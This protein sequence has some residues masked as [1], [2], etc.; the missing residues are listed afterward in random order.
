MPLPPEEAFAFI[1]RAGGLPPEYESEWDGISPFVVASVLWSLYSFLRTPADYWETIC[2]AIA[3]GGDTDTTAAMAGAISGAYLGLDAIPSELA[4]RLTDRGTWG[5][6]QL[7][8]L[9]EKCYQLKC[10]HF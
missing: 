3:A 8:E 2:T 6:V 9:A 1:S 4:H 7:V 5:Y 10:T